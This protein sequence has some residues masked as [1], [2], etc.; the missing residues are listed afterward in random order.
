[1]DTTNEVTRNEALAFFNDW[2]WDSK[3][4]DG[5]RNSESWE[6]ENSWDAVSMIQKF[7]ELKLKKQATEF[8]KLLE[9]INTIMW[10]SFMVKGKGFTEQDGNKIMQI[11]EK[12]A[13][14]ES[15]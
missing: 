6:R 3:Q 7:A 10:E 1:M 12:W 5:E 4:F 13:K 14:K 15:I 8:N 11:L 9:E 2:L